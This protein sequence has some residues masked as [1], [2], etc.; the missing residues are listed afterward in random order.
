MVFA[1]EDE[2]FKVK[3]IAMDSNETMFV[4]GSADGDIK[5]H[6]KSVILSKCILNL[7]YYQ[8]AYHYHPQNQNS[9][10]GFD[11]SESNPVVPSRTFEARTLQKHKSR[12]GA[13]M[14]VG[15]DY[16]YSIAHSLFN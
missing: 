1:D 14:T 4:T 11:L 12:S 7:S 15:T 10:V 3:C 2:D 13:G 6:I 16:H 9:G 8:S 5:V